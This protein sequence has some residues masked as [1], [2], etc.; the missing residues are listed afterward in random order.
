MAFYG[1]GGKL[2]SLNSEPD[3][4]DAKY[5]H[6]NHIQERQ[7]IMHK[8]NLPTYRSFPKDKLLNRISYTL[9]LTS[10]LGSAFGLYMLFNA[11]K[12]RRNP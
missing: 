8:V 6:K 3:M 7:A 10:L 4:N 5:R 12:F 11:P 1:Q 9:G 2:H